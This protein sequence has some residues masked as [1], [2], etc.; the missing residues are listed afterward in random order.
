[1]EI[2]V[3]PTK[4]NV[5]LKRLFFSIVLGRKRGDKSGVVFRDLQVGIFRK[6]GFGKILHVDLSLNAL[7]NI[8]LCFRLLARYTLTRSLNISLVWIVQIN[9]R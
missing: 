4:I 1:M 5:L 8:H 3:F 2:Y 6:F 7:E 9:L